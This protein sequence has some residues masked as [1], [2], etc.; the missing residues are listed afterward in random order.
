[1]SLDYESIVAELQTALETPIAI[2]D[3]YGIV[4][5]S[6]IPEFQVN[7]L[8]PP[9]ILNALEARKRMIQDLNLKEI[10]ELVLHVGES[11]LVFTFGKELF[12]ISKIPP[13]INLNDFLT[14]MHNYVNALDMQIKPKQLPQFH[15]Y[16]FDQ[17]YNAMFTE[18]QF[19]IE[20]KRLE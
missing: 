18:L 20:K 12:F 1:M 4:L 11:L 14:A 9:S 13:H 7:T 19:T 15:S 8:I 6:S 2:T 10:N 17:E 5:S 16:E 3:K